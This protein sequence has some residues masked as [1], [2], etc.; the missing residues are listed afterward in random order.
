MNPT[1][2]TNNV[3]YLLSII[4]NGSTMYIQ[5]LVY[6]EIAIM[7]LGEGGRQ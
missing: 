1:L 4:Q 3:T 5:V 6:I 7:A 2:Q